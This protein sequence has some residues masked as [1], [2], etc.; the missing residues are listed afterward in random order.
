[1]KVLDKVL[2]AVV[3]CSLIFAIAV[4][5]QTATNT[6]AQ[7]QLA[8]I[9]QPTMSARGDAIRVNMTAHQ[10]KI[11]KYNGT[12]IWAK[13]AALAVNGTSGYLG[14]HLV[15]D[16]AGTYFR[17]PLVAGDY[18]GGIFDLID[19][20]SCSVNLDSVTVFLIEYPNN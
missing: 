9:I 16:P 20:T 19:S 1:M 13:G 4:R 2:V 14:V 17:M 3:F 6:T 18:T 10:Y 11:S 8:N 7:T 12:N 15:S 5:T